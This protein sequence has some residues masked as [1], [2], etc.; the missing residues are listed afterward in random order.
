MIEDTS[1]RGDVH[2]KKHT[3]GG[4]KERRRTMRRVVSVVVLIV[5]LLRDGRVLHQSA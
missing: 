4:G 2:G 5:V 3:R 1:S